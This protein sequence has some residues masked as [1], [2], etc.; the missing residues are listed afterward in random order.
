MTKT[1]DTK[2]R[3]GRPPV[4]GPRQRAA[5]LDAVTLQINTEGAGSINLTG[6]CRKLGLSRS[7]L[8][9]YCRDGSDLAFQAYQNTCA[10]IAANIAWAEK[11]DMAADEKLAQFIKRTLMEGDAP[12][13]ALNDI[14]IL[15]E[16]LRRQVL[17]AA[18]ANAA[19][20]GRLLEAGLTEG[21]FRAVDGPL[22][23]RLVLNILSWALVSLPWLNRQDGRRSRARYVEAV[24]DILLNGLVAPQKD[25][26]PCTLDYDS[27]IS[28][29]FNAFDR[30]QTAELKVTQ[31]IAAASRLFNLKG[32]DGVKLD[33]VSDKIGA[34]KGAIYHH[35]KDKSDLIERCYDRAFDIYDLIMATGNRTGDTPLDRAF[36][37]THLNA[38][39][40]L[41]AT[42]PLALQPGLSKL[43]GKKRVEFSRRAKAL[44][45]LGLQNLQDGIAGEYV[46]SGLT[47]YTP[48]IVAGYFLGLPRLA[49]ANVPCRDL[50]DFISDIAFYGLTAHQADQ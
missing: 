6:L 7:S 39:A 46:R 34:T 12:V 23:A 50:A 5:L 38:Q 42:P 33:D 37:V 35:F 3:R 13:A 4:R 10:R 31:V 2:A 19:A 20:L 40:Q 44:G 1:T 36:I 17:D 18:D 49:P 45:Q 25:P 15:P 21:V 11:L 48:E 26:R 8:Y 16:E 27:L 43:N 29:P 41:S 24:I 47:E 30:S 32:L 22:A 14:D 28:Q 9:Y